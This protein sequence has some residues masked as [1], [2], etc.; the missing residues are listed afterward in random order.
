MR[1][2]G[3]LAAAAL[4][5]V[6]IPLHEGDSGAGRETTCDTPGKPAN[7]QFILKDM[8]GQD[9]N[10]AAHKGKVILLSFWATWCGPC[11][12]EI[13]WFNEFQSAYGHQ[14]LLVVGVSVDDP[15]SELKPFAERMKMNFPV[16][17]GDGRDDLKEQAYGPMWGIPTS[18]LIG[19]DG[20][21]C[22]KH[23]GMAT[24]EELEREIKAL[25]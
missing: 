25:L 10:L 8:S 20:R 11:K 21:I 23:M 22:R 12:I 5:A 14:G 19:R 6:L 18:F 7:L 17:V 9:F 4:G 13:P 1:W 2:V 3:V 16:L 24:R 15:V